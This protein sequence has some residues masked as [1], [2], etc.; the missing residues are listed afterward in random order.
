MIGT[1]GNNFTRHVFARLLT[2]SIPYLVSSAEKQSETLLLR[3]TGAH[4]PHIAAPTCAQCR[5]D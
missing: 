1:D 2:G 5:S 3:Q 4:S